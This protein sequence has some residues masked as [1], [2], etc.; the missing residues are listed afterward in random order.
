MSIERLSAANPVPAAP[1]L[2]DRALFER[3]VALPRER[4]RTLPRKRSAIVLAFAAA[5]IVAS[6]TYGVANWFGDAVQPPV[7]Q[8]EYEA[9]QRQ[10]ALPP[11]ATW[12]GYQ[13]ESNS[14]TSRGAGG[15]IAV[16]QAIAAWE[17]YWAHA[18][19]SGDAA[20][21][22]RAH[23]ELETLLH[24]N[25]VVAPTN[26]SENWAPPYDPQRPVAVFADDGGYQYK[27][28]MYAQAA[29]GDATPLASSCRVNG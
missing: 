14:V 18:I 29:A 21:G 2:D 25:V 5:A 23:T 3:I 17:C 6:T 8:R 13:F 1:A 7:T 12:P 20:A 11:G 15:G 26:A 10:L 28:R 22:Q 27:E 24:D 19:H 16:A 9:A 4:R